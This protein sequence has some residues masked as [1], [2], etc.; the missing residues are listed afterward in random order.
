MTDKPPNAL[1]RLATL[2]SVAMARAQIR[3]WLHV[4]R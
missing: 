2:A 3:V 1:G 4:E